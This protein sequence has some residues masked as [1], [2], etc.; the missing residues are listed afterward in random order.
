MDS[1]LYTTVPLSKTIAK[2]LRIF[3]AINVLT[4]TESVDQAVKKWCHEKEDELATN[5]KSGTYEIGRA[6]KNPKVF[7]RALDKLPKSKRMRL[8]CMNKLSGLVKILPF[9]KKK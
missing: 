2:P 7:I 8:R 9:M 1:K 6:V 4:I 5:I 3:S